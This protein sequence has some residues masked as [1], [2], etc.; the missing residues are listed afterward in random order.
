MKKFKINISFA[1]KEH[2]SDFET[3]VFAVDLVAAK[4][5]AIHWARSNGYHGQIKK[6]KEVRT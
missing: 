5:E 6:A 2:C 3:S 1:K 4:N